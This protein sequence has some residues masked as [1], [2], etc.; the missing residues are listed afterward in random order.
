LPSQPL[1]SAHWIWLKGI[2]GMVP[3]SAAWTKVPADRAASASDRTH[4]DLAASADHR[5]TTAEAD[6]SRSSMTST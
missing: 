6:F 2:G 1:K 5:T 3:S 4:C